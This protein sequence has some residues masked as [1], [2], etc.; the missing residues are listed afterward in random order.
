MT[1][2]SKEFLKDGKSFVTKTEDTIATVVRTSTGAALTQTEIE[3]AGDYYN[4]DLDEIDYAKIYN[5]KFGTNYLGKLGASDEWMAKALTDKTYKDIFKK[6]TGKNS[7]N[8]SS[9][10]PETTNIYATIADN[11]KDANG[12]STVNR[13]GSILRYPKND[14]SGD[15]DYLKV[16][17]YEYKPRG[18]GEGGIGLTGD[19]GE[20][21]DRGLTKKKGS[22]TVFLP[23]EPQ[24]L[25]EGNSVEWGDNRLNALTA[26]F[27]DAAGAG[28][29]GAK[30]SA[31]KAIKQFMEASG[32]AANN[33]KKALGED[34][35]KIAAYFAG[36][37]VGNK[38]VFKRATG[39]VMNPNLELLFNGPAL[40]QFAYNFRFTPR[41]QDEAQEV[42]K[43]IK[44]FKYAM[45]PRKS[46]TE[47]FLQSPHVF[48]LKYYYK[49][50]QQHPFLNKIKTC[51]L[52]SFQVQYAPDGSYM[53]YDD[54]SM[55][56]YTVS[57]GFG[58][59]NP[60]YSKDIDE[61]S[62]DMGY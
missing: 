58:E 31:G 22:H 38:G 49:N 50:G 13:G 39:Q 14:V 2:I 51:A 8:I 12:K 40:R 42:K 7:S 32:D 10:E 62:N 37:A 35:G 1:V 30:D 61:D 27:A 54:G 3:L 5:L 60:I 48:K 4:S 18:F 34:D 9:E 11:N 21:E 25:A 47:M 16:C 46:K 20:P 19:Y 6:A 26:A 52:T 23:M 53:T 45:A 55:T 43:I 24:G 41:E 29:E 36:E 15:Y 28:I 57:M 17:A 59:L 44:F 56:S 33:I